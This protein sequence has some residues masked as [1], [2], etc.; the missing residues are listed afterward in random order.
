[1]QDPERCVTKGRELSLIKCTC[2]LYS[3]INSAVADHIHYSGTFR[4]F[5]CT[6]CNWN[7][8]DTVKESTGNA[9]Y[10]HQFGEEKRTVNNNEKFHQ[11]EFAE[12]QEKEII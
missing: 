12:Q 3:K 1:M 8:K 9:E 11:E 4:Q 6:M 2:C 10:L 7:L 5:L